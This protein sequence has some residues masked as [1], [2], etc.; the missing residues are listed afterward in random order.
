MSEQFCAEER[1]IHLA[2]N[3]KVKFAEMEI[4]NRS[5][6]EAEKEVMDFF[7]AARLM[8]K[9]KIDVK[10]ALTEMKKVEVEGDLF[11]L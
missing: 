3:K 8:G 9:D 5:V 7:K 10:I 1:V 4:K 2:K 11:G 6:D